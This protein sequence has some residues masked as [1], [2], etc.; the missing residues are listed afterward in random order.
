MNTIPVVGAGVS[1]PVIYDCYHYSEE[2]FRIIRR[3][4]KRR[5]GIG[6]RIAA[7]GAG[8]IAF[9]D[10]DSLA[11]ELYRSITD[12]KG[13]QWIPFTGNDYDA[14]ALDVVKGG[15][16]SFDQIH[17]YRIQTYLV[18]DDRLRLVLKRI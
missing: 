3:I 7:L 12:E 2:K 8:S 18:A 9:I 5:R 11:I 15:Y 16:I 13:R 1:A 6:T 17:M 10:G 4:K 14:Q